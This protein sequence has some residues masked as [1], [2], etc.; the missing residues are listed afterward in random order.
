MRGLFT[1]IVILLNI[2]SCYSREKIDDIQLFMGKPLNG[3]RIAWDYSSIQK[4]ADKGGYPRLLRLKDS[5]II[6]VYE[7]REGNIAYKRSTDNGNSWGNPVIVFEQTLYTDTK[8]DSVI[9][10]MANPEIVQLQNGDIVIG[11]NYRPQKSEIA[12]FSIAI[13]RSLDNGFTWLDKQVLYDAAPRFED[14]CWEPAFLQLP[15]GEL[16]IYFA[17][18]NPFQN[19]DEQEI[20]MLSS[21]DNGKS[22]TSIPKTVSFREGRR[23]GMPV[24][25]ITQDEIVVIIEDNNI[26]KFKPYTVRTK[27]NDNWK[28]PVLN[29][30]QQREY[31]LSEK[32][33][34]SIYMGA[35][36]LIQLPQGETLISY[37]TNQNRSSDIRYSTMEVAIGDSLARNFGKRSYPF[38][39]PLDKEANWNSL[40]HWDNHTVVALSSTNFDSDQVAPYFIKGYII[41]EVKADKDRVENYPIFIGS[42]GNINLQAGIATDNKKLYIKCKVK[43]NNEIYIN[44]NIIIYITPDPTKITTYKLES[45]RTGNLIC[46]KYDNGKWSDLSDNRLK[47][48]VS[49]ISDDYELQ[50]DIPKSILPLSQNKEMRINIILSTND[51]THSSYT[52]PIVNSSLNEIGSWL[53]VRLN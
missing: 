15:N 7:D 48:T 39:V 9:I 30:S 27:I 14:G 51:T 45:D 26:D 24:P 34:D 20:S 33:S 42:K 16:Q 19:S 52:E 43:N 35:P 23:D 3:I 21:T 12:P 1:I 50:F 41:P 8:G 17:N 49:E 46:H 13:C 10:N 47:V 31:A 18:E 38:H 4:I 32:M 2:L 28:T 40:A 44:S 53:K 36:Y 11:C 29:N 25:I 6:V 22:W 5:S 37:Q